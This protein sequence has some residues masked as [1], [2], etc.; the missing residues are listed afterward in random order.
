VQRRT[1]HRLDKVL[2]RIHVLQGRQL[3]L[4]NIDEV[5]RIIRAADE[6]KLALMER[7]RLSEI[8][9]NDILEIRLRQLA[10]LEAIK[11]EQEL[12]KLRDER[13]KLE[14]ILGSAT[15]LR[16]TVIKEIEL[17]AKQYGDDR[18]TLIQAEKRVT[19]EVRIVDE[20]VTVIVSQKGWVRAL[21]GHEVDVAA[22]TFKASDALWG[23]FRC[24]SVDPL[25]VMGSN[26]RVYAVPVSVL[27]GGRGDGQPITT[28]IELE[29]GSQIAHYVAGAPTQRLVMA[30]TTGYGLVAQIGDLVGRQ[31]AG[32]TFLALDE[33]E[34]PLLALVPGDAVALQLGVLSAQGRLLTFALDELKHQPKGGKG[35]MLMDLEAKDSVAS[36][37][38]F[39]TQLRVLGSGRGGKPRD[40]LL[41]NQSL[42]AHAGKRA[43]KGKAVDGLQKV[44]QLSAT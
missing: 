25:I 5:I 19:A 22:Q 3:V 17:D 21:K 14:D 26:G 39:T 2:A 7:F 8:Q 43:R 41:R 15:A 27:P 32:K 35:L 40:E 42:A 10:R 9:A 29:S 4:L 28:L 37:A 1:Q 13:T 20:P 38:C 31:K 34:A 23:A 6:P 44:A 12:A 16:R 24:R 30:G 11:I 18:R 36:V 33:G